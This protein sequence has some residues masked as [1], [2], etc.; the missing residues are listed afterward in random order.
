MRR[1]AQDSAAGAAAATP[2]LDL[3][4]ALLAAMP[5]ADAPP[6]EFALGLLRAQVKVSKVALGIELI[7][8]TTHSLTQGVQSLT[9][10]G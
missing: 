9:S 4:K 10:H 5:R 3:E 7:S 6:A 1:L 8:K 2:E